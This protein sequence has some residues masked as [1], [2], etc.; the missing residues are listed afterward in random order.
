MNIDALKHEISEVISSDSCSAEFYFLIDNSG[1]LEL[2]TIDIDDNDH[3]ELASLFV[4]SVSNKVLLNDDL[5]VIPISDADDR[6]SAVY[7]YDLDEPPS[8]LVHL[9]NILSRDDFDGFSFDNDNF[10]QLKGVLILLGNSDSQLA[11]YKHHYP[12][13]VVKRDREFPLIKKADA[14]RFKKLDQDILRMDA[15]F[16]FMKI[17]EKYYIFDINTLQRFFGFHQAIRNVA[18]NGIDNI[19]RSKVVANDDIFDDRLDDITFA[20]KLVKCARNSPVLNVIPNLDI[21]NFSQSYVSLEGKFEYSQDGSQFLLS[22]KK[23]Q[24]LFLKLLND[25]F[26]QSEL[27]NKY[28]SSVAKDDVSRPE[29]AE[30]AT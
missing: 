7:E 28:Y 19:K 16:E 24:D 11:L 6:K 20:R 3:I 1:S 4:Q 5:T 12:V 17:R 27:T 8:E 2:K 21:I 23:S 30:A 25:D 13:T 9:S 15:K 26:L 14:N 10:S 18:K 22:T 29:E